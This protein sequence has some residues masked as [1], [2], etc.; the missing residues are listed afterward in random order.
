MSEQFVTEGLESSRRTEPLPGRFRGDL[1]EMGGRRKDVPLWMAFAGCSVLLAGIAA[2][3]AYTEQMRTGGV[4]GQ[5]R[6]R[7]REVR[8][9]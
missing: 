5:I 8:E 4:I 9:G 2:A 3:C 7:I 6:E 1:G